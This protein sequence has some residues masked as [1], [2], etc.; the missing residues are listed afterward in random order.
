[1][2]TPQL[3]FAHVRFEK[4]IKVNFIGKKLKIWLTLTLTLKSLEIARTINNL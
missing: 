4:Y 2:T 3:T 1:M